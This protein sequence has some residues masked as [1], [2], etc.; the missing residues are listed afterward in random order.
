[1]M[2]FSL[3]LGME[4][5]GLSRMSKLRKYRKPRYNKHT[6]PKSSTLLRRALRVVRFR[7]SANDSR[8]VMALPDTFNTRN[9]R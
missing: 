9:D 4:Q 5:H 6:S 7:I 3:Y 8:F 1:M 2:V